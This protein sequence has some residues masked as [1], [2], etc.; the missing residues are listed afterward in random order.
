MTD[1]IKNL[2]PTPAAVVAMCLYGK[3]YSEQK[4]GSMDFYDSLHPHE[5]ARCQT[6]VDV[7]TNNIPELDRAE[8][9]AKIEAMKGKAA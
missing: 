9:R 7:V 2:H 8:L 6:I 3:E 1:Q 4:G 5:K